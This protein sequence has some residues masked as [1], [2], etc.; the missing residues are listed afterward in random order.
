MFCNN[1]VVDCWQTYCGR[2]G[3]RLYI[4]EMRLLVGCFP[5][6]TWRIKHDILWILVRRCHNAKRNVDKNE[7]KNTRIWKLDCWSV[8]ILALQNRSAVTSLTHF[9]CLEV[10][11][12]F[13]K[14]LRTITFK[15]FIFKFL[16]HICYLTNTNIIQMRF[17][18][19]Y[20]EFKLK[21]RH[22]ITLILSME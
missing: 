16:Y 12:Q 7:R 1:P 19:W 10:A 20:T 8:S 5:F 9:L 11:L 2:T 14:P 21:K 6:P 18:V 13:Y 4:S 17:T 15:F 22:H 3:N